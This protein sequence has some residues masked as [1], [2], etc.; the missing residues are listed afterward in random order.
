MRRRSQVIAQHLH[1]I[2]KRKNLSA[3]DMEAEVC[4][5]SEYVVVYAAVVRCLTVRER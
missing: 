1:S 3:D 4:V 2:L 5:Y